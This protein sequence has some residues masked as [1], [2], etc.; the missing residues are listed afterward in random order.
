MIDWE[1]DSGETDVRKTQREVW[2]KQGRTGKEK[3]P[4]ME[5]ERDEERQ[6]G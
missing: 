6:G 2:M 4:L 5:V 1:G 3:K